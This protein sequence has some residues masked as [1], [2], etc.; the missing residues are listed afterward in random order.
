[1]LQVAL[2]GYQSV[3]S[4]DV[5]TDAPN[6][7]QEPGFSIMFPLD[8]QV[9]RSQLIYFLLRIRTD[10]S[11]NFEAGTA[12]PGDRFTISAKNATTGDVLV[13]S[14]SSNNV[15]SN[16]ND[17]GFN[18]YVVTV[19]SD[20]EIND[21]N[22]QI[23]SIDCLIKDSNT[24]SF[25]TFRVTVLDSLTSFSYLNVFHNSIQT[26]P[27]SSTLAGS[28]IVKL[29]QDGSYSVLSPSLSFRESGSDDNDFSYPSGQIYYKREQPVNDELFDF[30]ITDS[31]PSV[32]VDNVNLFAVPRYHKAAVLMVDGNL[33]RELLE[34]RE[35]GY[36]NINA[37]GN[38]T[39]VAT[40]FRMNL[41]P[42]LVGIEIRSL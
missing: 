14:V 17:T 4:A 37:T 34:L 2:G 11:G 7:Y 10:I 33:Q 36:V 25:I 13:T 19:E 35:S 28:G 8:F 41:V 26:R 31:D 32:V 15:N 38:V 20:K 9:A 23:D 42:S 39:G 5:F 40:L 27:I 3:S 6:T 29:S 24:N 16:W 30:E 18:P 1:M 22:Y 21:I 12:E